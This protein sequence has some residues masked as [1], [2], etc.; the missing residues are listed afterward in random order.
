DVVV[1]ERA[2]HRLFRVV[3]GAGTAPAAVFAAT[4]VVGNDVIHAIGWVMADADPG[5][6]RR[7]GAGRTTG[8][9]T[10]TATAWETV[11]GAVAPIVATG[12]VARIACRRHVRGQ[13]LGRTVDRQ[14]HRQGRAGYRPG[15]QPG[16]KVPARGGVGHAAARTLEIL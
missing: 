11:D 13:R 7:L 12:R 2:I 6:L 4:V 15:T 5:H 3:A 8:R 10:A 9:R 16:E 14:Q 1:V